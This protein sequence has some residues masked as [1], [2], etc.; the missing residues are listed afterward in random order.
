L[1]VLAFLAREA[2]LFVARFFPRS[3][4]CSFARSRPRITGRLASPAFSSPAASSLAFFL[5]LL[6]A[7]RFLWNQHYPESS[8]P[9]C[10]ADE[11]KPSARRIEPSILPVHVDVKSR[12][13]VRGSTKSG[14]ELR[15]ALRATCQAGGRHSAFTNGLGIRGL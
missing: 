15:L 14:A 4:A 6:S 2:A 8:L 5:P 10:R 12:S 7:S 1:R 11:M 9:P 3:Y 13:G